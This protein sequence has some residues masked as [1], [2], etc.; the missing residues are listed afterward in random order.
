MVFAGGER[1][2]AR[3]EVTSK[4]SKLKKK[5]KKKKLDH[6]SL[7]SVE[8]NCCASPRKVIEVKDKSVNTR[9]TMDTRSAGHIMLAEMFPRVKLDRTSTIEKFVAA[10]GEHIKDMERQPYHSSP[11]KECTGACISGGASVVKPLISMRKVV[12]A[13]NVVVLDEN[14]PH[15]RNNRYGTVVILDVNNG[16]YTGDVGVYRWNWSGFQLART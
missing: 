12:R 7:L 9:A 2:R 11:L 15:I 4:K 14:N 8:N 3:Q 13:G 1:E 6:E 10:I 16:V 5:K